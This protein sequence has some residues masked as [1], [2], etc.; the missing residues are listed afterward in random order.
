MKINSNENIVLI[1]VDDTLITPHSHLAGKE[2]ED[3]IAITNGEVTE[4]V[5][6]MDK[7]VSLLKMSKLRG[8]FVR[9][10][11]QS[12]VEWALRVVEALGLTKYVDSVETKPKWYV[13]DLRS[14]D[15]M[16]RLYF[17]E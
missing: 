2:V 7:H 4:N 15:W 13:D 6:V 16:K 5:Y 12:G 3:S 1:D 11:S 9:V 8:L 10:H 17:Y 14:D